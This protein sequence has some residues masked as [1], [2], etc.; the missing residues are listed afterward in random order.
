M[1]T[2]LLGFYKD[3]LGDFL[4][5]GLGFLGATGFLH[6]F[7]QGVYFYTMSYLSSVI[8]FAALELM[9]EAFEAFKIST[10]LDKNKKGSYMAVGQNLRY[11]FCRDYHLF[12]GLLRVTGGLRGFDP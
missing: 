4:E 6:T 3:F 12:K 9:V 1:L 7:H 5:V 2:L 8:F 10:E 11:L